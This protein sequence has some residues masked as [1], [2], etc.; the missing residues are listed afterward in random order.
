[1]YSEMHIWCYNIKNYCM[2]HS[3]NW[4]VHGF[5]IDGQAF[6]SSYKV[7]K[8]PHHPNT[9]TVLRTHQLMNSNPIHFTI[10]FDFGGRVK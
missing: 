5:Q 1:M 6:T 7:A 3:K 4:G 2:K 8:H 10:T 9:K